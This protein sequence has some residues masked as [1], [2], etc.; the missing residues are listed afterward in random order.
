MQVS[1]EDVE[2][3]QKNG[4][5]VIRKLFS[6]AHLSLLEAGI[7]RNMAEPSPLSIVASRPEDPGYFIEDFCNWQRIPEYRDFVTASPAAEAA[8]RLMGC[9][10]VRLYHDHLLVKEPGTRETTPWHQDQPYYPVDGDQV[11]S[12][13][14]PLDPVA[15]ETAVEYA[16]GSHRWGR[17]FQPRFFKQSVDLAVADPRFEPVPD[18]EKERG[19]HELLGW[20]MEPGDVIAFHGL[21]LHGAPGNASLA[22]RRRAYSTRWLGAD[23]RYAKRVG[24]ISPPIEGH[25]LSPGDRMECD[26][27]PRVWPRAAA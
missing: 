6:P 4:A 11:I 1:Q 17:W 27:F 16:K 10:T 5:V 7:A 24:Q 20:S 18:M 19:R 15:R 2:F 8:G 23:T 25:G 21:T 14:L 22:R 9:K 13:W 26:L 3:Y 12:L